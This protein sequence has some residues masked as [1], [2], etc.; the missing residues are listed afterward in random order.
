V[1]PEAV[2]VADSG[3]PTS[4]LTLSGSISGGAIEMGGRLPLNRT[5]ASVAAVR[6]GLEI[7]VIPNGPG[8]LPRVLLRPISWP[9][10]L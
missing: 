1:I 10:Y 9:T 3:P 6:R 7:R 5:A 2:P 4:G 8:W